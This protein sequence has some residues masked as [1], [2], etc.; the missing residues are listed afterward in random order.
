[1]YDDNEATIQAQSRQ[2][3]Y[4]SYTTIGTRV[5]FNLDIHEFVL[6][7]TFG[8]LSNRGSEG[9]KEQKV[10]RDEGVT[11]TAAVKREKFGEEIVNST[12]PDPGRT[13]ALYP[14]CSNWQERS[15]LAH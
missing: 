15:P 2:D 7:G 6:L 13:H 12:D 8:G 5:P 10:T 1:M 11:E 9:N 3:A 14:T 4:V